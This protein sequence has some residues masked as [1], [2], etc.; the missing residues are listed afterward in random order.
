MICEDL[1]L[2]EAAKLLRCRT[3]RARA[4]VGG[5]LDAW[6]DEIG[7]ACKAIDAVDLAVAQAGL[8]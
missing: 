6:Q 5:L 4:I 1:P 8:F 2:G 7:T 3:E